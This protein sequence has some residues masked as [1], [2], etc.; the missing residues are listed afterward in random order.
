M[1]S[2]SSTHLPA[3]VGQRPVG[4]TVSLSPGRSRVVRGDELLHRDTAAIRLSDLCQALLDQLLWC[5]E[6]H[7]ETGRTQQIV[8]STSS[9]VNC[10]DKN[11]VGRG[12][13]LPEP[14]RKTAA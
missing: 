8:K 7:R 6:R 13:H 3:V 5:M 10:S 1:V 11:S 12:Y 2:A 4:C 9:R 14:C